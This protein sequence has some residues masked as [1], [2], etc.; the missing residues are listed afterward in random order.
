MKKKQCHRC[1]K[2]SFSSYEKGFWQCPYCGMDLN[3]IKAWEVNHTINI[4]LTNNRLKQIRG[5][6]FY[7]NL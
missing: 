1:L 7:N 6:K 3:E 5:L 4:K 2:L